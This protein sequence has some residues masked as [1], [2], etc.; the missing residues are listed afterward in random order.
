[1][2]PIRH[3]ALK[4]LMVVNYCGLQLTRRVGRD[5]PTIK[6]RVHPGTC[7]FSLQNDGVSDGRF[8]VR[9]T[10]WNLGSGKGV[11]VCKEL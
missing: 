5:L 8:G 7:K 10:M 2:L 6:S 3:L 11:E 1:M 9:I 4:I